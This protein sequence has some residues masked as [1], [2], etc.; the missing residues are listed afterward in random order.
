MTTPQQPSTARS[1]AHPIDVCL[2]DICRRGRAAEFKANPDEFL[3]RYRLTDEERE[4]LLEADFPRLYDMGVH[5]MLLLYYS[6]VQGLP[7]PEYIA[8]IQAPE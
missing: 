6:R 7:L 2:T 4:A 3:R 1:G 5:P 8:R